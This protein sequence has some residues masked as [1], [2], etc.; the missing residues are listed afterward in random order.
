MTTPHRR[1][2]VADGEQSVRVV[3]HIGNGK[4]IHNKTVGQ[5][6]EREHQKCKLSIGRR[7]GNGHPTIISDAGTHQGNHCLHHRQY[8]GHHYGK[9]PNF[10]NH[11]P[12][13]LICSLSCVT[14]EKTAAYLTIKAVV[15]LALAFNSPPAPPSKT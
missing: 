7:S 1:Y 6:D 8:H 2:F 12:T 10:R 3:G 4:V 15:A 13:S 5:Q 11:V 14:A 9:M